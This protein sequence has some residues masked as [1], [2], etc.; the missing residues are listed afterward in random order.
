MKLFFVL[1]A[2]LVAAPASAQTFP[3][4]T[5]RV[6]DR[7]DLLTPAE[8][9]YLTERLA[10]L[11]ARTT[12]QLVI[13]TV[14]S[15]EGRTVEAYATALANRWAIGR[16]DKDNGVL[17]L[18]A[19]A[20]GR[21]RIAVGYGLEQILTNAR[22]QVIVDTDLVPQFARGRWYEGIR[23]GARAIIG[24]LVQNERVPR[25]RTR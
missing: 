4:L 18:V 14:R 3:P 22:A 23:A 8:E 24:L 2:L 12:D 9:A 20:D 17:L 19:P 15:L 25:R 7:A 11:E 1:I 6:V 5:G 13:A 16:A 10:A 21:V